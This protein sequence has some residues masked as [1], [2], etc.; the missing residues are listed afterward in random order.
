[1]TDAANA[2]SSVGEPVLADE[3]KVVLISKDQQRFEVSK[4]VA[5]MSVL[6]SDMIE[7]YDDDDEVPEAPL[8]NVT[9]KVLKKVWSSASTTSR[10]QWTRLK[11]LFELMICRRLFQ[12]GTRLL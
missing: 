3:G 10:P 9:G 1:M 6:V 5:K 12:N 4:A 8:M 2:G 7:E 11:S